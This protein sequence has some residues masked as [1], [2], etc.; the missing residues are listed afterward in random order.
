MSKPPRGTFSKTNAKEFAAYEIKPHD[1]MTPSQPTPPIP[2]A[3]ETT[4][5]PS[6]QTPTGPNVE[7][8]RTALSTSVE[9]DI[10]ADVMQ[11][12]SADF[13]DSSPT[14]TEAKGPETPRTDANTYGG[15]GVVGAGYV[16]ADF[17]RTLER[18][19]TAARLALEEAGGEAD[20]LLSVV[21]DKM[22]NGADKVD[23]L[24]AV[25]E[26][27]EYDADLPDGEYEGGDTPRD[28][29]RWLVNDRNEARTQR[30]AAL[31]DV[32]RLRGIVRELLERQ[33][34]I[35]ICHEISN[36]QPCDACVRQAAVEARANEA[37][38]PA[39]PKL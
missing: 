11:W 7:T 30:D 14:P 1:P 38:N 18:N 33:D 16:S 19:L 26:W 21:R 37:L 3:P 5:L 2:T 6:S 35:C 20:V 23:I 31:A 32:E 10:H 34:D 13:D 12:A 24:S 29:V 22:G 15:K 25:T 39:E 4:A 8:L 9:P 17:A 28:V 27:A 36:G